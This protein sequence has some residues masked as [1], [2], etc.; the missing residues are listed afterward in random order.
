MKIIPSAASILALCGLCRL[1]HAWVLDATCESTTEIQNLGAVLRPAVRAAFAMAKHLH[2]EMAKPE[3]Q[4]SQPFKDLVGFMFGDRGPANQQVGAMMGRIA[5]ADN[6][7]DN[8]HIYCTVAHLEFE[9]NLQNRGPYSIDT[10]KEFAIKGSD[11]REECRFSD[12]TL[13]L[14]YHSVAKQ[15]SVIILCPDFLQHMANSRKTWAEALADPNFHPETQSVSAMDNPFFDATILHELTHTL[16]ASGGTKA[17]RGKDLLDDSTWEA[18]RRLVTNNPNGF[19][20]DPKESA[21]SM[22]L[23]GVGAMLIQKGF[24]VDANGA[25]SRIVAAARRLVRGLYGGA[26]RVARAWSA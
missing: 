2:E 18:M 5:A 7:D 11:I 26:V 21:E 16:V 13:A 6:A 4:Q 24:K 12:G 14:T 17:G 15:Y 23:T 10:V 8:I 22:A 25:I 9:E 1:S 20:G 3:E 19:L